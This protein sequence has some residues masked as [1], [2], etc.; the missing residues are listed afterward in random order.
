[1]TGIA[2]KEVQGTV[3]NPIDTIEQIAI[4]NDWLH[5]RKSDEEIVIDVSGKWAEFRLFFS[6]LDD[7]SA[8]HFACAFELNVPEN[9]KAK[10]FELL[11]RINEGLAVGHFDLWADRGLPVF[12][13]ALLLRGS[14]GATVEQLEDLVDIAL[15]E[16]EKFYPAFQYVT[17]GGKSPEEA[18]KAALFETIGEA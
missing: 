17:W 10:I 16:C 8:M 13:A 15:A 5:E 6:W 7:I 14:N 4:S 12:R 3:A 18:V 1:M 2:L 11:S 9:R